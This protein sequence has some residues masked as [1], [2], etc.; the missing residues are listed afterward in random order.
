M[1]NP[2]CVIADQNLVGIVAVS[3]V[4]LSPPRNAHA[5]DALQ[6]QPTVRKHDVIHKTGSTLHIAQQSEEHTD[7]ATGNM[8]RKFGEVRRCGF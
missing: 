6:N 8:Q 5:R 4:V 2:R 7:T 3:A 1:S